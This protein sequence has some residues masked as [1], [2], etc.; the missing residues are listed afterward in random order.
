MLPLKLIYHSGYDL[1]L[2]SHVFPSKKFRLI[3]ERLLE[4]GF[5]SEEDFLAPEP[6]SDADLMLVHDPN[7]VQGLKNNQLGLHEIMRLEIPY[8]KEMVNGFWL[9]AGGSI[10]AGRR[11]LTDGAAYNV[12]GG[13]HHAF[14]GHGEG[15]CA[16]HDV[17]VA[18][19][20]LQS[21]GL[22]ERAMVVDCDVHHGN[23]TAAIFADDPTVFTLSIHQYNNYPYEKPP[24]DLDIHLAD[25][26]EDV[27]YLE[28]LSDGYWGALKSFRPDLIFYVAGG[29]PYYD[30]QLGG[31][32]L[33]IEGLGLRD[34][35]V[36]GTAR[37]QGIPVAV[38]LAGGY[39]RI[40][41]DT[42]TIQSNTAKIAAE[43][44]R[45]RAA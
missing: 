2:G 28:K 8:S 15:F 33:T 6:A 41:A 24:S 5:A 4:E 43:I 17:A 35:L 31:L 39:A 7:W 22:I 18:I 21:E 13:F 45:S 44:L 36:M 16:I 40:V 3:R 1:N 25:E 30:D 19:R 20:K 9:A 12:G 38:A 23:G 10:L 14:P 26:V 29:D 37:E 42:I 27:E 32:A 34:R 11:A